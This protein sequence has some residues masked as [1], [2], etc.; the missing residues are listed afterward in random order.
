MKYVNI[1]TQKYVKRGARVLSS[2]YL[3]WIPLHHVSMD[4]ES[5]MGCMGAEAPAWASPSM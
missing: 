5:S 3:T 4:L 1:N 2:A